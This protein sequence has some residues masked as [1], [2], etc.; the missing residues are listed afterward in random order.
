[1]TIATLL[2]TGW[3]WTLF[4]IDPDA[5][6]RLGFCFYGFFLYDWHHGLV[7]YLSAEGEGDMLLYHQKERFAKNAFTAL[8]LWFLGQEFNV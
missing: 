6:N 8:L 3:G 4:A 2:R 1:M 5:T 7:G